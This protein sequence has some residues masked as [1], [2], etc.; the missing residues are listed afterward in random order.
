MNPRECKR[1]GNRATGAYFSISARE[2]E[3]TPL[4]YLSWAK[5]KK[6]VNDQS[7]LAAWKREELQAVDNL[8]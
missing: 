2:I 8:L 5:E 4:R 7:A 1:H 6:N 3:L